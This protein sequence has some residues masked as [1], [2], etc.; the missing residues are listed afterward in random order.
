MWHIQNNLR[1]N[2]GQTWSINH[3]YTEDYAVT[4]TCY[5]TLCPFR[6]I[7]SLSDFTGQVLKGQD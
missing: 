2:S 4:L 3:H 7:Y 6:M 1:W 5:I